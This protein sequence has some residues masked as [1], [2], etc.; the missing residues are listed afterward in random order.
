MLEL[1]N[2]LKTYGWKGIVLA[3]IFFIC[4]KLIGDGVSVVSEKIKIKLIQK[5]QAR[6]S[7]HGFFTSMNYILNV[8]IHSLSFFPDK[9]VRQILTK[10]LIFCSL[11][12][13]N[14][15]AEKIIKADHTGWSNA[16]W[17][18]QM[19]NMLNEMNT[20]FLNK[21]HTKGIPEVVYMK[22]LEWYFE[23]LNHMRN[24]VDQV[25]ASELS[26]T[27]E[28]KTSTLLLLFSLFITTMMGDCESAMNELNGDITG[29]VY[30][31][32]V[33]EPLGIHITNS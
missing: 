18:F 4:Y 27:P 31:G 11:S 7:M 17:T 20:L 9:P 16:E 32:G 2:I 33:I 28:S 10:D 12:S 8:E 6:L 25:A 30:N 23:R 22:Y 29:M 5:R 15:V 3:A 14:E 26:P 1:L 13:M 24:L 19:R 21:C